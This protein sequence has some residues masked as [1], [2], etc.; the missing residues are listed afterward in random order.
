M[1]P[2]PLTSRP[3]SLLRRHLSK[4]DD[5]VTVLGMHAFRDT[6]L[7]LVRAYMGKC[8]LLWTLLLSLGAASDA[9]LGA[10]CPL[11]TATGASAPWPSRVGGAPGSRAAH[12]GIKE[13]GACGIL[14]FVALVLCGMT[15]HAG[16]GVPLQADIPVSGMMTKLQNA[17]PERRDELL[18]LLGIDPNWRMHRVSD[19]Q[20]R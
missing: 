8:A 19:G 3:P 7:N 1:L 18:E 5:A 14:T 13:R 17:Y 11:Q 2:E 16:Y 12:R 6:K 10:A 4:P 9:R 20:R 15:T